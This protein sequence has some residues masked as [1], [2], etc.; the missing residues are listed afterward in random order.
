MNKQWEQTLVKGIV[1]KKR[2]KHVIIFRREESCVCGKGLPGLPGLPVHVVDLTKE[3]I[4]FS[5]TWD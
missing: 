4:E 1:C 2:Q 3:E 5:H